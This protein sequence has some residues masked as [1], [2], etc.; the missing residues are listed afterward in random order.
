MLPT[1]KFTL[2]FADAPLLSVTVTVATPLP[3][4]LLK[5]IGAGLAPVAVLPAI[6]H[7]NVS[8]SPSGSEAIAAN[9]N[10]VMSAMPNVGV[11]VVDEITGER[12]D[13][14]AVVVVVVT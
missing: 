4:G 10:V 13:G 9:V 6:F 7:E 5:M 11:A 2:A 8:E 12:L 14:G 3:P 1:M